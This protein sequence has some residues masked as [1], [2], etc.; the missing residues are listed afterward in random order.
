MTT[1]RLRYLIYVLMSS[2]IALK[3]APRN[4]T[5]TI[6]SRNI[7]SSVTVFYSYPPENSLMNVD[8]KREC[9][10]SVPSTRV[11]MRTA[12]FTACVLATR[13]LRLTVLMEWLANRF[14]VKRTLTLT[15]AMVVTTILTK[16]TLFYTLVLT[17]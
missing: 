16:T 17:M 7:T 4:G 11:N 12:K 1:V 5:Q 14:L 8:R 10:V 15:R 3:V 9:E 13:V 2:G 6:V